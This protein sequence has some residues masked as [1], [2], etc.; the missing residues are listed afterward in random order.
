MSL[1]KQ[2]RR[3]SRANGESVQRRLFRRI[4]TE[5]MAENMRREGGKGMGSSG[6]GNGKDMWDI[7]RPIVAICAPFKTLKIPFENSACE[8]KIDKFI[9]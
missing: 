1:A 3:E 9:I 4:T 6:G 5:R 8:P 2:S 7:T